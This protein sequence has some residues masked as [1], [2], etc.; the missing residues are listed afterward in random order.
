M[1][2]NIKSNINTSIAN[3]ITYLIPI[4]ATTIPANVVPRVTPTFPMLKKIPFANSGACGAD[5][6]I[7][8]CDISLNIPASSPHSAMNII[9]GIALLHA[10]N[11][12][13][14]I[15]DMIIGESNTS[16][17]ASLTNSLDPNQFPMIDATPYINR[18]ILKF[19]P[20]ICV[21]VPRNSEIYE[22]PVYN[23]AFKN[24]TP[25]T[26]IINTPVFATD[27]WSK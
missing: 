22:Y 16:F 26:D 13:N 6:T 7:Q 14:N 5:D 8:Y 17:L 15:R 24:I 12:P 1:N 23:P 27:T 4:P 25:N 2:N 3:S 11:T 20:A 10:M 21:K 19:V 18:T 9:V